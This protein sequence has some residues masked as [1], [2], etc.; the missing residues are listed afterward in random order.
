MHTA[1][2]EGDC[3]PKMQQG[4]QSTDVLVGHRVLI[5]GHPRATRIYRKARGRGIGDGAGKMC[6]NGCNRKSSKPALDW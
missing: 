6:F 4:R 3:A 2:V 1:L 5:N